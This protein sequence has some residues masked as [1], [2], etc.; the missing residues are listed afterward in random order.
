MRS[1]RGGFLRGR[2]GPGGAGAIWEDL[3]PTTSEP[4]GAN[5]GDG[6]GR[7]AFAGEDA[8]GEHGAAEGE[9]S[10]VGLR[11]AAGDAEYRA[12]GAAGGIDDLGGGLA[13]ARAGPSLSPYSTCMEMENSIWARALPR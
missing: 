10:A 9:R 8:R 12:E 7:A 1:S 6:A 3:G 2:T 5:R 11:A 4:A 13:R